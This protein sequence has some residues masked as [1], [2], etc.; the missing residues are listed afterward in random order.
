MSA[1]SVTLVLTSALAQALDGRVA[2]EVR[3]RTVQE[4][5]DDAVRQEPRLARH[6][7]DES[8]ALRPHVLCVHN[9]VCVP[10]GDFGARV[11]ADGDRL[12]ILNAVTG[13]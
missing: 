12:R 4:A 9:E 13:G 8:G 10:R 2:Y 3:G 7:R 1:A 11:L 5:L 6:L